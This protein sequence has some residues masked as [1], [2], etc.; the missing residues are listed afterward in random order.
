MYKLLLL[1]VTYENNR[2]KSKK[3]RNTKNRVIEEL[4]SEVAK[5]VFSGARAEPCSSSVE[6]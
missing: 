5:I 1:Y 4:R 3:G 6:Q 2:K